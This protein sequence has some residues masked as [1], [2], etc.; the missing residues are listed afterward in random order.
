MT[1][2]RN[3]SSGQRRFCVGL[4]TFHDPVHAPEQGGLDGSEPELIDDQLA[5]I[6]ELFSRTLMNND[7]LTFSVIDLL[8]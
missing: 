3:V 6:G 1:T 8:N 2:A 5:L 4:H 7:A